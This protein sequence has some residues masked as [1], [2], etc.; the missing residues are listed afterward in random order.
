MYA[1][2][3]AA[4]PRSLSFLLLTVLM[5]DYDNTFLRRPVSLGLVLRPLHSFTLF[6]LTSTHITSPHLILLHLTLASLFIPLYNNLI[7]LFSD[8]L[9][10][11]LH[12]LLE[13][14]CHW[15]HFRLFS[16]GVAAFPYMP[17]VF[18]R[19]RTLLGCTPSL[20]IALSCFAFPAWHGFCLVCCTS[21]SSSSFAALSLT[22]ASALPGAKFASFSISRWPLWPPHSF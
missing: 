3:L 17:L 5:Y 21:Y 10:F 12:L 4:L 19:S 2:A 1:L 11:I 8:L 7:S 20:F 13:P 6:R 22:H 9:A 16:S 18:L 15:S 14:F